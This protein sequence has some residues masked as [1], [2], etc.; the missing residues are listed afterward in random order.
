MFFTNNAHMPSVFCSRCFND[1]AYSKIFM[2]N[3]C[4]NLCWHEHMLS[5]QIEER[6]SLPLGLACSGTAEWL[7]V[8]A[9]LTL[10]A[11]RYPPFSSARESPCWCWGENRSR[12]HL[13]NASNM[14]HAKTIE[15]LCNL[16]PSTLSL[17]RSS[18]IYQWQQCT[19]QMPP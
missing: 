17:Y 16:L 18:F 13:W 1:F 9:G 7:T 12:P 6:P 11:R 19:V 3:I 5:L 2:C 10:G 15:M 14:C 8:T 4:R